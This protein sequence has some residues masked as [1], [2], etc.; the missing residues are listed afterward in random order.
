[1]FEVFCLAAVIAVAVGSVRIVKMVYAACE[2]NGLARIDY[3]ERELADANEACE[4]AKEDVQT[5]WGQLAAARLNLNQ[6]EKQSKDLHAKMVADNNA[7]AAQGAKLEADNAEAV[8]LMQEATATIDKS[9]AE[10]ARLRTQL[11]ATAEKYTATAAYVARLEA[12]NQELVAAAKEHVFKER[13][14]RLHIDAQHKKIEEL[15]A[16]AEIDCEDRGRD[17]AQM[18]ADAVRIVELQAE[19]VT[20]DEF[21]FTVRTALEKAKAVPNARD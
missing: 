9:N 12:Q 15:Q 4:R 7:L 2:S 20:L 10:V 8:R 21:Y 11:A 5:T 19:V 13:T 1:M 14:L 18:D 3:L 16:Q 17:A 6:F